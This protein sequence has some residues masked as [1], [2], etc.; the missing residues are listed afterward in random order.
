MY[1][2]HVNKQLKSSSFQADQEGDHLGRIGTFINLKDLVIGGSQ[3]M[4]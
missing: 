4:Y 1:H 2:G 3:S